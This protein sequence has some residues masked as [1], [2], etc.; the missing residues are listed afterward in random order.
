[1]NDIKINSDLCPPFPSV[2]FPQEKLKFQF[3]YEVL[4]SVEGQ[5]KLGLFYAIR[6]FGIMYNGDVY[7]NKKEVW[8]ETKRN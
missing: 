5:K 2:L 4:G 7:K 6:S 1:M 8:N 3:L